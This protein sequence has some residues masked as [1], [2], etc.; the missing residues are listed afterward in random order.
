MPDEALIDALEALRET[1]GGR[2][3]AAN[4]LLAAL[5]GTAT[6]LGKAG[7]ALGDYPDEEAGLDPAKLAGARDIF[8]DP[9]LRDEAIDPLLPELRRAVKAQTALLAG[10]KDAVAA[11]RAE[12]VD[13]VRLDR[14][15]KT[16]QN[17]RVGG[18]ALQTLLPGLQGEIDRAQRALGVT[19]GRALH[20]AL[21]AQGIEMA[22]QAPRFAMERFELA[23]DF[24][25]RDGVLSYGKDVVVPRVPLSVEAALRAYTRASKAVTGRNEDGERWIA[26]LYTAW[27]I[28]R[29]RRENADQRAN[30]VDCY[31]ELV[32]QRQ[33]RTFHS[34]PEKARFVEYTRAQFAYDLFEFA[35]RQRRSYKGQHVFAHTAT[36]AQAESTEKSIWVVEGATPYNGRYVGDLVFSKDE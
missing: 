28:A 2:Q 29:R 27:D 7:R 30:V 12:P 11:L 6:A 13:V 26:Q 8:A 19:F 25:K 23:A 14:A 4:G 34:A 18:A 21:A 20:D 3:R 9:R 24:A 36:K 1:Y 33:T 17:A 31:F 10:L 22:G 35:N 15:Y 5:K 16:L 32:L